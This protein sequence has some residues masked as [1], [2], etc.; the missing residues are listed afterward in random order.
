MI[1]TRPDLLPVTPGYSSGYADRPSNS[2]MEKE[3]H[4][5]GNRV[6]DVTV[7]RI[8]YSGAPAAPPGGAF[9]ISVLFQGGYL[10]TY[11]LLYLYNLLICMYKKGVTVAVTTG[12][13]GYGVV[14]G[15][16][17]AGVAA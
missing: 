11:P 14:R 7:F 17:A 15:G 4:V 2:L 9:P 3:K 16:C 1:P 13:P 5:Q 12:N 8:P 10:V 6:T